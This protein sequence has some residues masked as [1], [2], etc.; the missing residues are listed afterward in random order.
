MKNHVLRPLWLVLAGIALLLVARHFMVPDDFGVNGQNF[1]YGF[2]RLGSVADWENFPAKY[3]NR[4]YCNECHEENG[5][6][7][8][9]SRHRQ[10][11][12][13]NCHGPAYNHPDEPEKL[14]VDRGRELCLRCH[15]LLPYPG[16]LRGEL[17]GIVP[18]RHNPD[19]LC[20]DCHNPHHP[21]QEVGS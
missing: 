18:E 8:S 1:T 5:A 15:E 20:V 13:E 12:C 4:E 9:T 3:K 17:Q 7:N 19:G 14:V 10:I 21:D 11:Q 6:E 16:S 2:H